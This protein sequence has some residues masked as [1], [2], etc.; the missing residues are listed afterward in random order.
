MRATD[1]LIEQV[2]D[3]QEML[4]GLGK[5]VELTATAKKSNRH[6]QIANTSAKS[7]SD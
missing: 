6:R 2:V 1:S 7:S 3:L 4:E 5:N